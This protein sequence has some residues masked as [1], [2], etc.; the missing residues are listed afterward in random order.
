[1]TGSS[2]LLN[3]S[4]QLSDAAPSSE[5]ALCPPGLAD[6]DTTLTVGKNTSLTLGSDSLTIRDKQPIKKTARNCC[7]VLTSQQQTTLSIPYH[8]LLW[9]EISH[10]YLTVKYAEPIGKTDV[11]VAS[12]YYTVGH[13]LKL[14]AEIFVERLLDLSYG[15]AQRR[16]RVK[17]LVNPFG[18]KGR[19]AKLYY[20][21]VE[22]I[23]AAARCEIDSETTTHQGH[24]E[25]I[26]AKLD[27]NAFDVIAACSG[28]GL[29]YEII[30]GL[31]K[32]ANASEALAKIA[33]AHI[34]CGSG[35][36]MSWNI[37]GT[38][39]PS[40]AALCLVKGVTHPLDLVSITQ[41]DRRMLSFLSQSFGIVAESDLGTENLRWMGSARFTYGFLVRLF[42]KTVY[43]CDL[44]VKVEIGEK[45]QIKEHYR[46]E[47][48][49]STSSEGRGGEGLGKSAGLPPLQYGTVNDPLPEDWELV[50]YD[51][52]GNFYAGNMAFMAEDA[53]FFPAALPNDGLLDLITIRGDIP[54][55][56]AIQM[57]LAVDNG[58]LF[59]MPDVIYRKISGYRIIP[60][61]R[62]DGYISI[63]GEK[64]P[65]E[66]FQAEVHKGLGTVISKS[67]F[68][69]E[70]KGMP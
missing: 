61:G 20:K 45:Q 44:A 6:G 36:A 2:S 14:K 9:A 56:T 18:G 34:P 63:D 65:F 32:K 19:A 38:G 59:D 55:A 42:G 68:K 39:S 51:T 43:P 16:K 53:N 25:E 31:G 54:R 4:R 64:A 33:L 8:N 17:V 13:D 62:E 48:Q 29:P 41:G 52:M 15:D 11:A 30:N 58:T 35:N 69:Y 12:A 50:P 21:Y 57:L 10:D 1:M 7:G 70:T 5:E 47:S 46:A 3:S 26:A 37:N 22:P 67:G 49:G 66:P 27:I 28:D 40:M 60:K 23:L 24:A